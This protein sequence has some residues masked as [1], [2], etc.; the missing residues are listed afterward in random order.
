L[1]RPALSCA[2]P[3]K[4][5]SKLL[6]NEEGACVGTPVEELLLGPHAYV[7]M[8]EVDVANQIIR[9]VQSLGDLGQ[10]IIDLHGNID[11]RIGAIRVFGKRCANQ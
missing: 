2:N 4:V 3:S 8:I 10:L 5:H 7:G 11:G 1:A 6:Q 9:T